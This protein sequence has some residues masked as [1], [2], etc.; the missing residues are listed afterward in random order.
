MDPLLH[1][2]GCVIG[3][4]VAEHRY[5]VKAD[6]AFQKIELNRRSARRAKHLLDGATDIPRRI[7]QRAVDIEQVN[8]K[9]RD[10]SVHHPDLSVHHPDSS[11]HHPDSSVHHPDWSVHAG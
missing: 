7:E 3:E 4:H 5:Q 9:V 2:L 6:V 8:R 10:S 1:L 11:V